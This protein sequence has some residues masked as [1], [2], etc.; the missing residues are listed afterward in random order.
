MLF[1]ENDLRIS[2]KFHITYIKSP[3]SGLSASGFTSAILIYVELASNCAQG[4]VAISSG[5]FSILKNKC[6][7]FEFASEGDLRP[8]IQWSPSLSHFHTKNHPHHLHFR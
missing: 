7:K 1:D 3:M 5:D 8:L 4:D 6:S 2:L